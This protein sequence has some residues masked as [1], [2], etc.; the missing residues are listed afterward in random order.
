M[1]NQIFMFDDLAI[2]IDLGINLSTAT[3]VKILYKKPSGKYGSWGATT[4]GTKV[5][6]SATNGEIDEPGLWQFE[7]R[8]DVDGKK[9]SS[10]STQY[11]DKPLDV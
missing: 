9:S 10:I 4:S 8:A 3:D 6:Y 1:S 2:S 5:L 11:V 7:A